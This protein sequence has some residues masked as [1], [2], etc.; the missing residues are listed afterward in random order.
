MENVKTMMAAGLV[1]ITLLATILFGVPI[2]RVWAAN[3]NGRAVLVKAEQTRQVL[4]TQANA[5]MEAAKA[6]AQAIAIVGKAAQQYPEYRQQEFMAAF[7]E[8]L[9]EGNVSQII[10]VPTEANIPVLEAGKRVNLSA[11]N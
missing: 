10:Y 4:V 11:K 2:Y 9:R 7:G 8:A 1:A 3:Y 6:R 5:E